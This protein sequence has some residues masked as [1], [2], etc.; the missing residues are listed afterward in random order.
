MQQF[1]KKKEFT[2]VGP[3]PPAGRLRGVLVE[4]GAY[5]A[6]LPSRVP[7]YVP[8][9][10]PNRPNYSP[11]AVRGRRPAVRVDTPNGARFSSSSSPPTA[12]SKRHDRTLQGEECPGRLAQTAIIC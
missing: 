8:G 5:E 9:L 4:R 1:I 6:S 10:H 2:C 12:D 3:H 7:R 11:L